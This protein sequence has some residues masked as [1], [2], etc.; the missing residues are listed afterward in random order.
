[1]YARPSKYTLG[2]LKVVILKLFLSYFFRPSLLKVN[3]KQI[4]LIDFAQIIILLK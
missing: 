4:M 3:F 1:M 2:H